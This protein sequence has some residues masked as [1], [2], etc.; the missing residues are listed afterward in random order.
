M[1]DFLIHAFLGGGDSTSPSHTAFSSSSSLPDIIQSERIAF[2]DIGAG[3]GLTSIVLRDLIKVVTKGRSKSEDGRFLSPCLSSSASIPDSH[4]SAIPNEGDARNDIICSGSDPLA[5]DG[6]TLKLDECVR[7]IK[8]SST[9]SVI[10]ATDY[11][12]IILE[13]MKV[14]VSFNLRED[15]DEED[16][17]TV[18]RLD[19]HHVSDSHGTTC[20]SPEAL[21][22]DTI[23]GHEDR[24]NQ[25]LPQEVYPSLEE[26]LHLHSQDLLDYNHVIF[27]AR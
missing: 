1:C 5:R 3:S 7:R 10:Y 13:N 11:T 14:N 18:K 22:S 20:I 17:L 19:L 6:V 8:T 21:S 4:E 16:I 24:T 27:I 2:V 15:S 12:P 25:S 9:S 23:A 26:C